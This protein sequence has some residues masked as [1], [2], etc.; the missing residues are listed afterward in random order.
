MT[1]TERRNAWLR[2]RSG[3]TCVVIG[4]RSAVFAPVAKLGLII[5]DEEH[6]ESYKQADPDPRYNG[7]D[8]AIYRARL[9]NAAVVVGSATPDIISFLNA[10]TNRYRL[11]ELSERFGPESLPEVKPV[12]WGE[13]K[14]G[15]LFSPVLLEAIRL[16][17]ERQSSVAAG[18]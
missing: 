8:V 5:V 2:V 11:L 15:A 10:K 9:N 6:E 4:P 1:E 16:R 7:R 13:G 17:L 12:G 18:F 3:E 14:D